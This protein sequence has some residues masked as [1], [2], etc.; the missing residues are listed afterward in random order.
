MSDLFAQ[1]ADNRPVRKF[2]D[3]IIIV[4]IGRG[5]RPE[6]AQALSLLSLCGPKTLGVDINFALPGDNDEELLD[7]LLANQNVV[8]P[9]GVSSSKE[10][11]VFK[12]TE[13]PFFFNDYSSFNYGIV[14]LPLTSSKG[15]VRE[16]AI[17]FPTDQGTVPSF[18]TQLALL[19][20]PQSAKEIR[21][22]EAE[23][24]ITAYHSRE[25]LTINMEEIE[26]YAEAFADKI[27]L[28]GAL[29]DSSDMHAT[30][31]KSHV[32]GV[33]LHAAA[34]STILDGIWYQ[35]IPKSFDYLI[36]ISICLVLM[37]ISYGFKNNL[38]GIALRLL[39][40]LLAYGIVRI[41]YFLYVDKSIILDI[42]FTIMIVAFG[43]LASDIW[44]GIETLWKMTVAK[45]DKLDNKYNKQLELC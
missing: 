39:Q 17:D 21:N 28:L 34:L 41:G 37:L 14:N 13:M 35:K 1:I 26:N 6:I 11:G 8:L 10:N 31:V 7:A 36:A 22:R 25:Y 20:D 4:N 12:I 29:E 5:G 3:R 16:F 18:V 27:V 38:K 33:M 40:G 45:I 23:T 44:N 43:F 42:S 32:A 2:D 9:L 15:T 30:P 19:S 24:G